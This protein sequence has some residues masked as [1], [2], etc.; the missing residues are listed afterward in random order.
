M[1]AQSV[2]IAGVHG[3]QPRLLA[4]NNWFKKQPGRRGLQPGEICGP[5]LSMVRTV[6]PEAEARLKLLRRIDLRYMSH[7][8][9]S[10]DSQVIGASRSGSRMIG[11]ARFSQANWRR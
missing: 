1:L 4:G 8:N 7:G 2:R 5:I 10:V 9:T 6:A 3:E 11:H